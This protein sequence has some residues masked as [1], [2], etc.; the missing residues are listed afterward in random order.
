M[1]GLDPA[2]SR[3]WLNLI[4]G[5]VGAAGAVLFGLATFEDYR[6]T[7]EEGWRRAETAAQVLEQHADRTLQVSELLTARVA[8]MVRFRGAEYLTGPG[9]AEFSDL[10]G[11]TPQISAIWVIDAEGRLMASTRAPNLPAIDFSD[12]GYFRAL[13]EATAAAAADAPPAA[14]NGRAPPPP[15]RYLDGLLRGRVIGEWFFS[16]N[17]ALT[18]EGRFRGLVQVSIP[19]AALDRVHASLDLPH[20]SMVALQRGDGTLLMRWPLLGEASPEEDPLPWSDGPV[21]ARLEVKGGP[22]GGALLVARRTLAEPPLVVT[23]ALSREQV[24]APFRARLRRNATGLALAVTLLGGL[25]WAALSAARRERDALAQERTARLALAARQRELATALAER[26]RLLASLAG[27]EARLRLAQEVGGVGVWDRELATANGGTAGATA[28][29]ATTTAGAG[30]FC[31]DVFRRL[32]DLPR[33]GPVPGREAWLERVHPEDRERAA[34][35]EQ[36][37]LATG[38]HVLEF[39]ILRPDGSTR[40]I[41]AE[42]RVLPDAAGAPRR[43]LSVHRDITEQRNAAA[44][45]AAANADLELRVADRTSALAQAN[46]HLAESEARFRGIFDATFQFIGL[47]APDGTV[48]EVNRAALE[49]SGLSRDSVVGRPFW[50]GGWWD[51]SPGSAAEARLRQAVAEAATGRFVRFEAEML[52]ADGGRVAVDFSL[53]PV[54]G[55]DGQVV[56]LV[57]EARDVTALKEAQAQL[58]EVQKLETLGQITGGVA[59]DFNNL[60]MAVLGNLQLALKRLPNGVD[61]RLRRNIEGAIAGAERG[62]TLTQRLLAFARRQDLQPRAVALDELM[63]GMLELLRR[64]AGPLVQVVAEAPP[65]DLRPARVDPHQLELALLNLAVNARDA[66]PSGGMLRLSLAGE[67]LEEGGAHPAGLP[68]GAYVR[69]EVA[70]TGQG[71]D[72]VTLARA[73]EPFFTTKGP[74]QGTGLGLS[75]VH[76]LAAQSGGALRLAS[77]PGAGT[78]AMLWLPAAEAGT[79]AG[80]AGEAGG[81]E[82]V[83]HPPAAALPPLRVLVVDDEPLVLASTTDMLGDLGHFAMAASGGDAALRL[84]REHPEIDLLLT[85]FAMPDM[86]GTALARAARALRPG[87]PVLLATGY[88]ELPQPGEPGLP[89]LAKPFSQRLLATRMAEALREVTDGPEARA[90]AERARLA[91]GQGQGAA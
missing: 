57:P 39:R 46:A 50:E 58:H 82:G 12:R 70:D 33:E 8:D 71:M 30:A 43:L 87:L 80:A 26:E 25:A 74:G 10:A 3:H 28:T 22:E 38:S 69:I 66:M 60:L 90:A 20:G 59:H 29:T 62:A 72:E 51:R 37:A 31:S 56:L 14:R 23:A 67:T 2:A 36:E 11:R 19:A 79:E 68:P 48:L 4:L 52:R 35:A 17:R 64:S 91:A 77:Q 34:A 15:P 89:R 49:V 6:F 76:G 18:E 78:T 75:M 24:L 1:P 42:G 53:N 86:T 73:V 44:A 47:I 83:E 65:P 40:W 21:Q 7:L 9:W 13:R 81:T 84:L 5:S 63:A 45:L 85:D 16:Y 54:Q 27:S 41:R 55:E 32:Y 61:P 88:A